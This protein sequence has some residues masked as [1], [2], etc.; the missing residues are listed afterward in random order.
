VLSTRVDLVPEAYIAEISKLQDAVPPFPTVE[1]FATM[2]SAWG[3][4]PGVVCGSIDAVPIA[5]ASL[6]QVYRARLSQKCG[7]ADVAVKVLRP[8]A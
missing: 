3:A 6:G 7:G 1:A 5:A 8:G 2:S 4:P